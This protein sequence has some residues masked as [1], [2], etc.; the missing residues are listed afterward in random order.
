MKKLILS[1]LQNKKLM[2]YFIMAVIIV[3]LELVFFQLV[4]LVTL[5][6]ILATVLS[7]LFGVILNWIFGRIFVFGKSDHDPIKE[8]TMVFVAS[9]GGVLIQVGIVHL[10]VSLLGLYPLIGKGISIVFSF[11]WNYV[12]R[13][14]FI[15]K[16]P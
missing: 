9:I 1:L 5:Q 6:P 2:R 15:Y 12:F 10:T 14:R 16:K 11:I 8:F 13:A 3:G 4:Y 7:F